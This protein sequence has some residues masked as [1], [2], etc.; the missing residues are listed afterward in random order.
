M[1][2]VSGA[3]RATLERAIPIAAA[4]ADRP[5]LD[6]VV[7]RVAHQLRWRIEPHGLAVDERTGEGR[8][9]M[10]LEPRGAVHEQR[11]ARGVRLGKTVFAEALDLAED[12]PREAFVVT[13]LAH[14]VDEPLLEMPEPSPPFPRGHAPAQLIRLARRETRGH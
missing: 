14:A 11:E 5:H 3:R 2:V 8:G 6:T 12:L 13:A 10:A 1:G 9:L 7:A 4:D